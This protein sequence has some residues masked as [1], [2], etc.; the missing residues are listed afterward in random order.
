MLRR[1]TGL[2]AVAA[3]CTG[4]LAI[5]LP[6]A[7]QAAPGNEPYPC[8]HCGCGCRS[9][10]MCWND[11]CC[12]TAAEKVDW[13]RRHGVAVPYHV[14]RAAAA[15]RQE[16]T[17]ASSSTSLG[18]CPACVQTSARPAGC[19][20]MQPCC[21]VGAPM[22]SRSCCQSTACKTS[23][24][25]AV[26]WETVLIASALK[27][28]GVSVTVVALAPAVLPA[29]EGL[30]E[31]PVPAHPAWQSQATFYLAPALERVSPPPELA[32]L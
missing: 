16:R 27:C 14:L 7:R 32:V 20:A 6:L 9:A 24:E 15:E 5:P 18:D 11:C 4:N 25:R 21:R 23:S 17:A 2:M 29:P 1:F 12:Y 10:E 8:Q 26:R 13:A 19:G 28:R 30:S 3:I 31:R 22:A